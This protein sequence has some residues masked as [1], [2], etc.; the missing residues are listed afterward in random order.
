MFEGLARTQPQ[1]AQQ[2]SALVEEGNFPSSS[3]FFGPSFCG[4]MYA[5]SSLAEALKIPQENTIIVSDRNHGYRIQAAISLLKRAKNNAAK[6]F[7]KANIGILLQQYHGALMEEQTATAKKRFEDAAKLWELL[8][9]LDA[10]QDKALDALTEQISKQAMALVD[11]NKSGVI[12]VAQVR[13]IRDW[14][15][16]SDMDGQ[17]KLIIIEGLENALPSAVN[18]LLKTLEEPP[19]D[20]YFVIISANPGRLL[21]TILSRVRKFKFNALGKAETR[22]ILT[23]L[24]V[25][26]NKYENLEQFFLS[27]SGIDDARLKKDAHSLVA[28]K[29]LEIP[30]LVTELEKNK[31]WDLF[32]KHVLE[33]LYKG[34]ELGQIEPR[35]AEYLLTEINSML[36]KAKT[37]NQLK[38]LTFDYVV[39][40]IKEILW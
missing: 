25:D 21:A 29:Q 8:E 37:F 26:P 2:L 38:R 39:Y 16:T 24:F 36:N 5:A 11:A 20:S 15:A 7:L 33:E 19:R 28:L 27:G 22:Y 12:S 6:K 18:A 17:N 40:R 4:R 10:A 9:G 34:E 14:C 35:K 23:S 3:L 30:S 32:F 31:A 1:I 13:A